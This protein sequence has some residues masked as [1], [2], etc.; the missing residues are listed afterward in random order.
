MATGDTSNM[1]DTTGGVAVD[2]YDHIQVLSRRYDCYND[3]FHRLPLM[4]AV[5]H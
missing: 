4:I 5:F 1:E 3:D 2:S